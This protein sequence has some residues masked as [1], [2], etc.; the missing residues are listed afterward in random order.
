M[1]LRVIGCT[2]SMSGPRSAASCYLVQAHGIDPSTGASR[3]WNV[4]LD[5]GPGSFGELWTRIDPRDLD[6]VIFSHCHA[7]HMADIISLHVH[8]RWGPAKGM[9]PLILAGPNGLLDRIRQIDGVGEEEAYSDD[10]DIRTLVAGEPLV[11]GPM[12]ITAST[13]WHSVPG[14]GMRI[15]GPKESGMPGG[16]SLFYTGD[17]DLCD[18]IEV[19][20]TGVDLLLSE[21]GFTDADEIRGIHMT[22]ARA[23]TLATRAKVGRMVLTH[24]QPWTDPQVVSDAARTTWDGPVDVAVSGQLHI[25]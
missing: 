17:T 4:A 10:F 11:V 1:K 20:A 24:I 14:F 6:A 25:L 9:A 2:G 7:D 8:R 13:A 3:T 21:A 5:L 15:D 18:D 23:G 16:A 22:G 12:T 19:G